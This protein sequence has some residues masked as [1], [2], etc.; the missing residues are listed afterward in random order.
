MSLLV[1]DRSKYG[2]ELLIDASTVQELIDI[3][4]DVSLKFYMICI[5]KKSSGVY[6]L[7]TEQI[8]L[9]DNTLIFV[10]P[11]QVSNIKDAVFD[12]GIF[13]FFEGEFLDLFFNDT[14]FIFRFAFFHDPSRPTFLRLE[15]NP[16]DQLHQAAI[17]IRDEIRSLQPDSDHLLR[18]L[19]YYLLI[20]LNRCYTR[21]HHT[22]SQLI[23]NTYILRFRHLMEQEI[24]NTANVQDYATWLGI[25]RTYLNQLCTKILFTTA[26]EVLKARLLLEAKRELLFSPKSISEIAHELHFAAPPHFVRFFKQQTGTTPGQYRQD[27]SKW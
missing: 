6:Y 23:T 26:S 17:E 18:S 2:K 22:A 4:D 11:G 25:S 14:F 13:L 24:R 21:D 7:D 1:F 9:S 10:K 27:F 12:E 8:E 5:L 16:F 15:D 3:K 19:L 20:R